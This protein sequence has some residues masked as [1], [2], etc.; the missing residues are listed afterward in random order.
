[1]LAVLVALLAGA[2]A[3]AELAYVAWALWGP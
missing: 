2:L 3:V 1:M